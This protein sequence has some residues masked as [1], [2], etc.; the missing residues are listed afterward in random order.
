MAGTYSAATSTILKVDYLVYPVV[1]IG[2]CLSIKVHQ[3][4]VSLPDSFCSAGR[5]P[6]LTDDSLLL[7]KYPIY[8]V[9]LAQY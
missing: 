2:F 8:S 6:A 9:Q 7:H 3:S 1:Q 5:T 4:A